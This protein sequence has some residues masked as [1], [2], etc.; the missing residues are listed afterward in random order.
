MPPRVKTPS[1][2]SPSGILTNAATTG[3]PANTMLAAGGAG[4]GTG[5]SPQVGAGV[6]LPG[7]A[8]HP[9]NFVS[10]TPAQQASLSHN[11]LM[12]AA[13]SGAATN[14]MAGQFGTRQI[15]HYDDSADRKFVDPGGY[16]ANAAT[17]GALGYD[18]TPAP[19][20]GGNVWLEHL[21]SLTPDEYAGVQAGYDALTATE[22]VLTPVET[23]YGDMYADMR[24]DAQTALDTSEGY[25]TTE[26]TLA[27][28]YW[29][30]AGDRSGEYYDARDLAAE[31]YYGGR[32]DD[33]LDYLTGR[34]GRE[35]EQILGMADLRRGNVGEQYQYLVDALNLEEGRR[36]GVYDE[37]E[38]TRGARL[39]ANEAALLGQ[40]D[41]LEGERLAQEQLMRDAMSG[42][43]TGAQAGLDTRQAEA[44]AALQ[45]QG[46][47]PEAYTTAVGAETSAL[48]GS[49]GISS[50]NLQDRLAGV[51]ASEATD[52]A[53]GA[54][55]L[56]QDAR[57]ALA[58][59]LFGGRADLAE[60]IAGRR[61][62]MG[63]QNIQS[64]ADIGVGELGAQQALTNLIAQGKFGAGQDY[65]TGMYGAGEEIA[66]GRFQG[67]EA[68]LS[69]AFGAGQ[70]ERAGMYGAQQTYNAEV[71]RIDQLEAS[72]QISRAEAAQAKSEAAAKTAQAEA[73]EAAQ[74]AQIDTQMGLTP[75]TAQAMSAGGL[76]GD[77][78][79]DLMADDTAG[80]Y[81]NMMPWS[82]AGSSESYFVD[83]EIAM[84][85]EIQQAQDTPVAFYPVEINGQIVQM[86]ISAWP[87][88]QASQEYEA[89]R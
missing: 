66:A 75:G 7:T 3:G 11:Q 85:E 20:Q 88:I 31:G 71:S 18:P 38:T 21:A 83:P 6:G 44:A 48:L 40:M 55:G 80:A 82:P 4:G 33:T 32:R 27:G 22:G 36:G 78:Y 43:Y 49:Q 1:V 86:P 67:Q 61:T 72:G 63:L 29:G 45:A 2:R 35:Q 34:E 53:L 16:V 73:A 81:E 54:T 12:R 70:A 17:T 89:L 28:D 50:Q 69:G 47:G 30:G 51:A 37:L 74:F 8:G 13:T 42:R 84:R 39:D 10:A 57:S 60:D 79:G 26:G 19:A 76:L 64:L 46:V 15:G 62:G 24:D 5:V 56:F 68:A 52:R 87:D 14:P 25:F 65:G 9:S 41:T 23:Q 77:L 58:D 59:Q